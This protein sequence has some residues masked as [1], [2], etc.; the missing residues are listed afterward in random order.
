[1]ALLK[2]NKKDCADVYCVTLIEL[3]AHRD[4]FIHSINLTYSIH[5]MRYR[6]Q[7]DLVLADWITQYDERANTAY[8]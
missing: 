2:N 6:F 4:A 1:M 5:T 7:I 3:Q 8:N